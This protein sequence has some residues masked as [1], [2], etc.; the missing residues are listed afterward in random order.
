MEKIPV[1]ISTFNRLELLQQ[2]IDSLRKNSDNELEIIVVDDASTEPGVVPYLDSQNDISYYV[3]QER[4]P[5][6]E[7]KNKGV[8]M[9][10]KQKYICMIDNDVYFLPHWDTV[11]IDVLNKHK[12]IGM[13][14]S[15]RHPH[16]KILETRNMAGHDVLI[17]ENQPGYCFFLERKLLDE[18]GNLEGVPGSWYGHEDSMLVE[19]IK[20]SGRLVA[21]VAPPVMYH[22]GMRNLVNF[23]ADYPEMV[24][25]SKLNPNIKFL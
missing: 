4:V 20:R 23:A 13:V 7:V 11:L 22:C 2:T 14:G 25:L 19:K 6:A 10:S 3:F 17:M 1:V 9:S 16:H 24:E 8:Q 5:V 18:M 21:T 12:D 15:K